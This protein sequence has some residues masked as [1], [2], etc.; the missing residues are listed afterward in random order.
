M[1]RRRGCETVLAGAPRASAFDRGKVES[2]RSD[3]R[4]QREIHRCTSGIY[5]AKTIIEADE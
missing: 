4:I 3:S 1:G 5:T 2:G